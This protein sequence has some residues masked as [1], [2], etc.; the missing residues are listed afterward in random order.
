MGQYDRIIKDSLAELLEDPTPSESKKDETWRRI[1]KQLQPK[2][3]RRKR[4]SFAA[5]SVI[6]ILIVALSILNPRS[7]SA[8]LGWFSHLFVQIQGTITHLVGTSSSG[9]GEIKAVPS[10]NVSTEEV[11]LENLSFEEAQRITTFEILAPGYMAEGYSFSGVYVQTGRDEKI[12]H[13]IIRYTD[14]NGNLLEIRET[15]TNHQRGYSIGVDNDDT[16]IT[17]IEAGELK[18][19]ILTFK[20]GAKK[21]VIDKQNVQV[22]IDSVLNDNELRKIV[23]SFS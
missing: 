16:N 11:A 22:V 13:I 2:R 8:S 7:V 10:V 4:V 1:Q 21:L 19:K 17:E 3:I 18:G 12:S 9:N 15:D 14:H 5:A 6:V 20:N 23:Q